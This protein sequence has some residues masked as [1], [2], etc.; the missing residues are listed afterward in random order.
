[1]LGETQLAVALSRADFPLTKKG[2]PKVG[3]FPF[4]KEH[5]P[6]VAEAHYT[7]DLR[8]TRSRG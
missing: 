2:N 7:V 8:R 6:P 3:K 4:K 5:N 1:M